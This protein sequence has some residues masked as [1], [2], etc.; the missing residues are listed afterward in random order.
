[1]GDVGELV[2]WLR[3]QLD[4]D[5]A[6]AEAAT[7]G[8]W[9]DASGNAGDVIVEQLSDAEGHLVAEIETCVD[10]PD[11]DRAADA[12]HIARHDPAAV[13]ADVAAKR[14]IL[15][16]HDAVPEE[17]HCAWDQERKPC[18]TV[19]LLASAYAHRPGYRDQWRPT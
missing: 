11:V 5:Q 16:L 3:A 2:A 7:P 14:A 12:A 8:P 10:H 9:I 17:E 1:M 13:L 18:Q 19:R 4:D 15:D 6:E